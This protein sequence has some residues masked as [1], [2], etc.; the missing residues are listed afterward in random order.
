MIFCI[1]FL[2]SNHA[3]AA[4]LDSD[5]I[6]VLNGQNITGSDGFSNSNSFYGV[7]E[8]DEVE[9]GSSPDNFYDLEA[10]LWDNTS[11]TLGIV[12]NF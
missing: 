5:L 6:K 11:K 2:F 1:S 8:I 12:G 3:T 10:M 7:S 4:Y 9:P